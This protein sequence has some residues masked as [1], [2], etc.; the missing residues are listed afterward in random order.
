[1]RTGGPR[2]PRMGTVGMCRQEIPINSLVMLYH[3]LAEY[4]LDYLYDT[5]RYKKV[6]AQQM[7]NDFH[8]SDESRHVR[9]LKK[10]QMSNGKI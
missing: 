3:W 4:Y 9:G 8:Q 6:W 1:M 7:I 2:K 10:P 5:L